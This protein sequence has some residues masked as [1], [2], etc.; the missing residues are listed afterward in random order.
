M[1]PENLRSPRASYA[2]SAPF[3]S[4][5]EMGKKKEGG[6]ELLV[7]S[8]PQKGGLLGGRPILAGYNAFRIGGKPGIGHAKLWKYR[9][10]RMKAGMRFGGVRGGIPPSGL[11]SHRFLCKE[12]GACQA[13]RPPRPPPPPP[14]HNPPPP[15]GYTGS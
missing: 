13:G 9:R 12:S 4:R 14:T 10:S 7:P 8:P 5:K 11:S 6:G 2:D 15:Q 3:L 1:S